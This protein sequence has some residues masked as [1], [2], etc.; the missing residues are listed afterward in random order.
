MVK[1]WLLILVVSVAKSTADITGSNPA[2]GSCICASR[3]GINVRSNPCGS[4]VLGQINT[5]QCF[6]SQGSKSTCYLN[7][8]S[9]EFFKLQYGSGSGWVAGNFLVTGTASRCQSAPVP[10]TSGGCP[11][12]VTRSQWGA[13]PAT[14]SINIR[15]PVPKVFIHHTETG[16]CHTQSDCARIVRSIQNYHM[17]TRHW[18]DIGYNF[19]VG[20]DG[21]VYEGRGWDRVGAHATNW[22][23]VAIGISVI[24]SFKTS[25]PNSAAQNAVRQLIACG[26]SRGKISGSYTLHGHRD[27]VC[28]DCPGTAFYNLIK[29]WPR[30]GGR[31]SGGC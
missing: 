26:V 14:S 17:N 16:A 20:E 23:T 30:Y 4:V 24:G 12:I 21:N 5:G 29:T 8:V 13:R 19:L 6:K 1:Y 2:S 18:A 15:H 7:G 9:Y 10:S 11:R 3:T 28:T 25:L 31:L 27:G 22:N